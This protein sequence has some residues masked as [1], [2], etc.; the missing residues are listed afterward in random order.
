MRRQLAGSQAIIFSHST[1]SPASMQATLRSACKKS[2][3]ASTTPSSFSFW[4]I[5]FQSE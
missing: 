2:G 1:C 3:G 4:I 5:S